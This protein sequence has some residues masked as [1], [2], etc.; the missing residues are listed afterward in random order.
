MLPPVL[1]LMGPTASGKTALS[2]AL[3]ERLPAEVISVD[4]A[5]VYRG[6]DIGSAKPDAAMRARVPHHLI[7]I[8]D[9]T[10]P[11][12]AA[13][14]AADAR[15]LIDEI[16]ARHRTPLLVGGTMLYFR[17]LTEG[18][19]ELPAADPGLRA[20][21][22]AEAAISGAPAMH[23]RLAHLDP[24]AAAR[25]HPN[26]LQRVQRALEV[27]ELTGRSLTRFH[28]DATAPALSGDIVKLALMPPQRI[29]L[30]ARIERRFHSMMAQGFL[31]EV[32]CLYRR[33]DLHPELPAIRAV[34]YRQL[35]EH[36]Q[37]HYSLDEAVQ[38]G[39]AATRQFAKRQI[40]WLR[41]EPGLQW[42]NPDAP[43]LLAQALR[44]NP[45]LDS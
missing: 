41:S 10:E 15:R 4:S 44:A 26:D 37:G 27:I 40:T 35:W 23:A 11:Y 9:P 24:V 22:E 2:L 13:R 31:D 45:M 18:L 19:N 39:I 17:A 12:S 8:L 29:E 38:K 16:R 21:L 33:G 14:F 30:H 36:L 6:M 43:D 42:L 34:G 32:Q 20:R 7:D 5:L 28:A 1:L 3:A 25:L